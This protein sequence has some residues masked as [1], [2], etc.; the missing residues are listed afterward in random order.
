MLERANELLKKYYGYETFREGQLDVIKSITD[1]KDTVAIMPTGSGKSLCYQIP[2]LLFPGVTIVISPLISLMKDQVDALH[3]MEIPATFLNSSITY[4]ELDERLYKARQGDYK[5]IYIAPERLESAR[6]CHLLNSLD[7][8]LLAVDE[9]H[10][11]SHWG[12]DFRPSYLYIGKMI[13]EFHQRPVVAAFT[14]TATPEVRQD[15][16]SQLDLIN[17]E[18]HISGFNRENLTFTLRKGID[19][20]QFVMDYVKTNI[21]EAGIIYAAT[22]K[23]V[24]RVSRM[25]SDAGYSAGRYHAGLSDQE[26]HQTQEAF[27]YDE[28]NIVV[29]T[30]AFGMGIDKSNVHYVIHYNMPKNIEAY[31]QEAGRAGRDGE[32]SECILL[33]SPGDNHIQKFL[34]EQSESSPERKQKQ[35]QKLQEMVDYCHTSRCL[36][37]YILSYF[38]DENAMSECNNCS[39]CSDDRELIDISEEAQKV[40]SCIY[41]MEQRWGITI[42]AQVLAGSQNKKVLENGFDDLSTY[43][44]MPSK[45]IKDI[46]N[47]INMLAADGYL[48]LSEGKYP[49]LQLNQRSYRVLKGEEEVFQRI[50]KKQHKINIDNE[51]FNLLRNLRKDIASSEDVPPYVIFHDST[52]REMSNYYPVDRKSMLKIAGVGDIK[53]E[54]Y[55]EQFIQLIKKYMDEHGSENNED[56]IEVINND[57]EVTN[58][59]TDVRTNS[60][61]KNSY[62]LTYKLFK[63]GKNID[64]IAAERELSTITIENHIF[65][66]V[67][68][69]LDI[70]IDFLIPDKFEE[71]ILAAIEQEGSEKLKPIKKAL[72]EEVSYTA[73]KAVLCK[74]DL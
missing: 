62:L 54:K 48:N 18:I 56:G 35:L 66:A 38:G 72:P 55:G 25:L 2:A 29:A 33:Y 50:E 7:V 57:G 3:E 8:S 59:K 17:P 22:R 9:A 47:M 53:F 64:E 11:V 69:G 27:I 61:V 28:I 15:I 52:L 30:N 34:I 6:F 74:Y 42:T 12:H 73:I 4:N 51:L 40:L 21:S 63:A 16:S 5:L 23:E 14:A 70:D 31:Y 37:G 45:T 43:N 68:E 39:N 67:D 32:P 58:T 49:V 13:K 71:E 24:D 36:R 1:K 26:R 65:R 44:I 19:K 60:G 20:D 41:R 46:K 10:C